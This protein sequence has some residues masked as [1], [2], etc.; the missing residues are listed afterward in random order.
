VRRI[1]SLYRE[2]GCVRRVKDEADRLGL[3]MNR[4]AAALVVILVVSLG[5]WWGIWSAAWS[6]VSAL[7]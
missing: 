5:L 2:L 7:W 1:F 6:L 3:R 4:L